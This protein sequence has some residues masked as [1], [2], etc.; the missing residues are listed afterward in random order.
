MSHRIRC[1]L[2]LG[3]LLSITFAAGL[4]AADLPYLVG[5]AKV[6][7]TPDYPV[8]LSGYAS[9]GLKE[10]SETIQPLYA[11]AVSI[12]DKEESP[13]VLM[14]VNNCGVS[15][16]TSDRVAQQLRAKYQLPRAR[17]A[18]CS[19][20]THYAPMLS[21]VLPN[22]ASQ[23]IPH[24]RQQAID[25]DTGELVSAL[26]KAAS[27]AIDDRLPARLEF[28]IREVGFAANRRAGGGPSDHQLPLL[29]V[30]D[31]DDKV[32]SAIVGY[33]CHCTTIGTTP[34]FIGDWA[35]YGAQYLEREYP[36]AV[37]LVIIGCGGDQNPQPRGNSNSH[38]NTVRRSGTRS[39]A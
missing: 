29:T 11:R 25:R 19:T 1:V 32:R 15:A 13:M 39:S 2:T 8:M 12:G 16:E 33:A 22:L 26:V 5:T 34:A 24:Q 20:H 28:A 6:E 27:Q 36:G 35:G 23:S 4:R 21:G 3:V 10:V 17:L 9:R 30:C 37:A 18:I 31:A 7:I 14:M 38:S